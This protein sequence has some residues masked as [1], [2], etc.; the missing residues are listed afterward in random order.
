M[1]FSADTRSALVTFIGAS[2]LLAPLVLGL[3]I[4]AI[5]I[6]VAVGAVAVGLGLA[7]TADGGRGILPLSALA[8][9]D[10]GLALG[11]AVCAGAFIVASQPLAVVVFAAGA[12]AQAMVSLSTRYTHSRRV[13]QNFL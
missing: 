5:A 4:T 8:S 13:S 11:L 12:F 3:S 2:T 9:Y 7:G 10:A 1:T 6:G